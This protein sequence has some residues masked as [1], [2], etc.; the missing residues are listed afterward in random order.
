MNKFVF[1][2][3]LFFFSY[4]VKWTYTSENWV[5]FFLYLITYKKFGII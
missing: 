5:L 3:C 1:S 4:L 2:F